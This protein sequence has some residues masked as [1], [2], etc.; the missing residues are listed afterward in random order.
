[1]T[2]IS[3]PDTNFEARQMTVTR[4]FKGPIELPGLDWEVSDVVKSFAAENGLEH[5]LWHHDQPR[6]FV[7]RREELLTRTVQVAGY[8][9]IFPHKAQ[10]DKLFFIP[11]AY[12]ISESSLEEWSVEPAQIRNS[13]VFVLLNTLRA[14][15]VAG[16][17]IEIAQRLAEAWARA[18][19]FTEEQCTH[20]AGKLPPPLGNGEAR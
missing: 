9:V 17:R 7:R 5:D 6:W 14:L 2:R 3:H 1:M 15:P 10:E 4:N 16:Q 13:F 8:T 20:F 19:S 18:D 12:I 11:D